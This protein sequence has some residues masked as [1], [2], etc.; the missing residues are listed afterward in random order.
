MV[1]LAARGN[2]TGASAPPEILLLT[3]GGRVSL[4]TLSPCSGRVLGTLS[5][6][7]P[8]WADTVARFHHSL[9]LGAFGRWVVAAVAVTLAFLTL[10]GVRL[11]LRGPRPFHAW[12]GLASSLL[13]LLYALS[14]LTFLFWRSP[15]PPQPVLAQSAVTRAS[16][17]R[18]ARSAVDAVPGAALSWIEFP[19]SSTSPFSVRLRTPGDLRLRGST[20]V[21]LHPATARVLRVDHWGGLPFGLRLYHVF[22]ALHFGEAGGA[23]LRWFWFIAGLLPMLLWT[24]GL[25]LR[26]R[27]ARPRL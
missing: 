3:P 4:L 14:G 8:T 15:P 27:S 21:Y 11:F 7:E 10:S 25:L 9:A 2:G 24:T 19:A 16:L 12:L 20:T 22:A 6:D 26:A 1:S 13:L 23:R 18:L 5:G 17:D